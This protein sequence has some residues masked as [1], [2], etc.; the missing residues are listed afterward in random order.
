MA[1]YIPDYAHHILPYIYLND[2]PEFLEFA[3]DIL[4]AKIITEAEN[5]GKVY[6]AMIEIQETVLYVQ[7]PI[8]GEETTTSSLYLYVP[9]TDKAYQKALDA[10]TTSVSEPI[11][12]FF[13]DR[14][15]S[16]KDKWG[17]RWWFATYLE[18]KI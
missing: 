18:Q 13:G 15:A 10:G 9:D 1:N 12:Q 16:V 14:N 4:N 17:N 2:V 3:K 5:N 8:S 11:D 6:F 7:E